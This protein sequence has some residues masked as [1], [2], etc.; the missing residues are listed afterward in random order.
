MDARAPGTYGDLAGETPERL[1]SIMI[2]HQAA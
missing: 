1:R 2:A